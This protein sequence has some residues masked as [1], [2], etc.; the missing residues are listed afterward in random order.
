MTGLTSAV[1]DLVDVATN[2]PNESYLGYA[3]GVIECVRSLTR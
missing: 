1:G 3:K 2:S